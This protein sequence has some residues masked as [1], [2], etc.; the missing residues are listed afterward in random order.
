MNR[1][2]PSRQAIVSLTIR[3]AV[4]GL[5]ATQGSKKIIW[6]NTTQLSADATGAAIAADPS[7][8]E[9]KLNE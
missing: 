7:A 8:V 1:L 3:F 4:R 9:R 2:V 6:P 5:P